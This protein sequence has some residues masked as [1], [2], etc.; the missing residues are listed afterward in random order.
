[1]IVRPT[2]S[3]IA[4]L[5]PYL[6]VKYCAG[7]V[8]TPP[9][10]AFLLYNGD[11]ALYGGA[12]GGGK[13]DALLMAALQYVE[14]PDYHA[15]ILRRTFTDLSQPDAI[16]DRAEQWLINTDARWNDKKKTWKFPSGATLT[17]GYMEHEKDKYNYQG[18]ALQFVGFDELTQ[19][20]FTQ[21]EY[22]AKSRMRKLANSPIPVRCRGASNPPDDEDGEWVNQYFVVHPEDR[23]FVRATS[24]DNPHLAAQ[25]YERLTKLTDPI[26]RAKLR[27]GVWGLKRAAK[28]FRAEMF[29]LV[30]QIP[31]PPYARGWDLAGTEGGG[32]HTAGVK[33]GRLASGM[34]VAM[35][36]RRGQLAPAGVKM[37]CSQTAKID[38]LSTWHYVEQEGGQSGKDQIETYKKEVFNGYHMEGVRPSGEKVIRAQIVAIHAGAVPTEIGILPGNWDYQGFIDRMCLF[39][40]KGIPD[41]EVDAAGY[42]LVGHKNLQVIEWD[43]S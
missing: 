15:L 11:E 37:L 39:P 38:G 10:A 40:T 42:G 36:C 43:V 8:P 35:D 30:N 32:D 9:Q 26:L 3:D 16:M 28:L 6:P 31:R 1:M 18:A 34:Y 2:L 22:I 33:W 25:Y 17:F 27:D 19:F 21:Y 4:A 41:D 5:T 12:A 7:H 20:S 29:P 23:I 24:R 14:F 13:S